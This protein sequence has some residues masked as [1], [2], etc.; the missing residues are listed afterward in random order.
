MNVPEALRKPS[1]IWAETWPVGVHIL[2]FK[3]GGHGHPGGWVLD[4][5][6]QEGQL[7]QVEAAARA[8]ELGAQSDTLIGVREPYGEFSI[9]VPG[10][11]DQPLDRWWV[12][13]DRSEPVTP[14]SKT[15]DDFIPDPKVIGQRFLDLI[16]D[17][18][19]AYAVR[20]DAAQRFDEARTK[21]WQLQAEVFELRKALQLI[22]AAIQKGDPAKAGDIARSAALSGPVCEEMIPKKHLLELRTAAQHLIARCRQTQTALDQLA[23]VLSKGT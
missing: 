2:K 16:R 18:E 11:G 6:I 13:N 5:T 12:P 1:R 23:A 19:L 14:L 3:P 10:C 22:I 8:A 17:N 7:D 21:A 9:W 15:P 20:D 4:Q